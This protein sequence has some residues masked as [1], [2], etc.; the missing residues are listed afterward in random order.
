[1]SSSPCPSVFFS[2]WIF[3]PGLHLFAPWQ[4]AHEGYVLFHDGG[5]VSSLD[6]S[7]CVLLEVRREVGVEK[8]R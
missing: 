8:V 7:L 6:V 1:M 3:V 2:F 4:L 5:Y